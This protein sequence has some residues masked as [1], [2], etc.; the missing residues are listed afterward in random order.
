MT[1]KPERNSLQNSRSSVQ[2]SLLGCTTW[3]FRIPIVIDNDNAKQLL[4]D[5]DKVGVSLDTSFL[6][7]GK[8]K[9]T[10]GYCLRK[11][12]TSRFVGRMTSASVAEHFEH[13]KGRRSAFWSRKIISYPYLTFQRLHANFNITTITSLQ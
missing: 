4:E 5:A 9:C 6:T 11:K 8:R 12:K 2:I 7:V 13:G 1:P 10:H 3:K